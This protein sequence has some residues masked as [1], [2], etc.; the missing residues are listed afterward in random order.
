MIQKS[1]EIPFSHFI[2][3]WFQKKFSYIL[4]GK[5]S[6]ISPSY[7]THICHGQ[8]IK[9]INLKRLNIG[10]TG[11]LQW[12]CQEVIYPRKLP[13]IVVFLSC[14]VMSCLSIQ[15]N[16]FKGFNI[17]FCLLMVFISSTTTVSHISDHQ[18]LKRRWKLFL[19]FT[20]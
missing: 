7:R 1:L 13:L 10:L 19:D 4:L 20:L 8:G 6:V 5:S 3:L 9:S 14:P 11:N 2:E 16:L 15:N 12:V 17:L 18:A